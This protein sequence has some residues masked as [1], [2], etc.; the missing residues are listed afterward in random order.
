MHALCDERNS[1]RAFL[2]QIW[3]LLPSSRGGG[4]KPPEN[5]GLWAPDFTSPSVQ[6]TLLRRLNAAVQSM[7]AVVSALQRA[8]ETEKGKRMAVELRVSTL[9]VELQNAQRTSRVNAEEKN[10]M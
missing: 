7:D 2:R 3:T 10:Q 9:E 4:V 8:A 6:D 1:L 5:D